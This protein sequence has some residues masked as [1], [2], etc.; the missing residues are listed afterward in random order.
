VDS[1]FNVDREGRMEFS[2]SLFNSRQKSVSLGSISF[3]IGEEENK[4][5]NAT[6]PSFLDFLSRHLYATVETTAAK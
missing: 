4:V 6:L 3:F 2:R 5:F 1:A